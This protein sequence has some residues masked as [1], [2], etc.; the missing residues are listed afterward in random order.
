MGRKPRPKPERLGEK[1]L[2]IRNA[3]ELS[4]T[5]MLNR[6][7]VED[8][9]AYK[10]ISKYELDITEPPL[11]LLLRYAQVAGIHLED[12]VDDGLDLPEKLPGSVRYQGL[13]R[14]SS[15]RRRNR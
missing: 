5:E 13:R 2:R 11:I 4:Q 1:L 8:I 10:Q 12:I 7:E 14:N 3:L 15:T 9:I 6:L